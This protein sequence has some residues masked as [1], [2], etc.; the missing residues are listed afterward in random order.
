[1]DVVLSI[2]VILAC[3]RAV[4]LIDSHLGLGAL[5]EVLWVCCLTSSLTGVNPAF[6]MSGDTLVHSSCLIVH[7]NWGVVRVEVASV[8]L[9]SHQDATVAM[10]VV[11]SLVEHWS[12]AG[13]SLIVGEG[14]GW[15]LT[16]VEVS[17]FG[18]RSWASNVVDWCQRTAQCAIVHCHS[19]ELGRLNIVGL[20]VAISLPFSRGWS[21]WGMMRWSII[22]ASL[23]G[24]VRWL[25]H[26][27]VEAS[28]L[29]VMWRTWYTRVRL[30]IEHTRSGS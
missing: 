28:I 16:L 7:H 22:R 19:V 8:V 13:L 26:I 2:S 15:I 4:L 29:E 21:K 6:V 1:M 25:L 20:A 18:I 3:T 10:T 14:D 5:V 27:R 17:A 24:V 23:S 30:W 11:V 12:V 9:G